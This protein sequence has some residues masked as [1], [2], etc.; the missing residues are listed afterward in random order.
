MAFALVLALPG[1]GSLF[2]PQLQAP[3]LPSVTSPTPTA[4]PTATE[5][6]TPTP[7]LTA[8][9]PSSTHLDDSDIPAGFEQWYHQQVEWTPST[10][11]GF[12]EAT[13]SAPLSWR[14]PTAGSIE[15]ALIRRPASGEKLGSLLTNPGG[16]GQAGIEF[17]TA[18]FTEF[19]DPVKRSYDLI[20]FDP[21]GVGASTPIFCLDDA[22]KDAFI[23]ADFPDDAAGREAMAAANAAFGE[24][25]YENTGELLANVDTMSAARDMDLIRH[26]L[27]DEKLNYLG[28][29]YGTQLGATYAGLFPQRVGRMVL[30]GAIDLTLT[31]DEQSLGQAIGFETALR[32]Y[33]T[34]CQAGRNCPLTGSV[35]DGLAQIHNLLQRLQTSPLPTSQ[36]GRS[37]NRTLAFYG[38]ALPLYDQEMW[39]YLSMALNEALNL[40]TGDVLLF[41]ADFYNDRNDDGTFNGNSTEAFQSIGCVD[42][43]ATEDP[44]EMDRLAEE[45]R[46]AAPTVGEFFTYGGLVCRDWP[47]PVAPGSFDLHAAGAPPILV[48]GTT[49]DPATPYEW[50]VGLANTLD[51]GVLLTYEGEGHTAYTRS[52]VCIGDTVDQFLVDGIVPPYGKTC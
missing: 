41:L 8:P 52:N 36:S 32:N 5:L 4:R 12:E 16:P 24:A 19:G 23:S 46:Q 29:S 2:T 11:R 13:I 38:I 47:V 28:F 22:A 10:T 26:L 31:P 3:L 37:V 49:N 51:S 50:A 7:T 15:L 44:G 14:D 1:C 18:I 48:I 45:L 17:L 40:G 34:D 35:D 9:S 43:R 30:D 20:G 39:P 27:D 25:C 21:R 33:V 6:P 42:A